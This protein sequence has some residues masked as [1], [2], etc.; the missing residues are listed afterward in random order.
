MRT[1]LPNEKG[2]VVHNY[3]ISVFQLVGMLFKGIASLMKAQ[4][5]FKRK[6]HRLLMTWR[7]ARVRIKC[8][9]IHVNHLIRIDIRSIKCNLVNVYRENTS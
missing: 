3:D 8:D 5:L 4:P 2:H 9:V 1:V 7:T 6:F